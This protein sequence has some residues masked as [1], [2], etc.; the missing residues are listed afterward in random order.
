MSVYG[1]VQLRS[2]KSLNK[3]HKASR[4][5]GTGGSSSVTRCQRC[6]GVVKG[7]LP[8]KLPRTLPA[9]A[10]PATAAQRAHAVTVLATLV[11]PHHGT[12]ICRDTYCMRIN[13]SPKPSF[14][15]A[16]SLASVPIAW[17][18]FTPALKYLQVEDAGMATVP[19]AA[20]LNI[21]VH[22]V[23]AMALFALFKYQRRTE[24][25]NGGQLQYQRR[26]TTPRLAAFQLS[27]S[28]QSLR[29]MRSL[30]AA[31]ELGALI[32]LGREYFDTQ[33]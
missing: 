31:T 12:S 15:H 5:V 27:P 3:V 18:T 16:A 7:R 8:D 22:G 17:G 14:A 2:C 28:R 24:V 6:A 20:L 4:W 19:P 32:F 10:A 1:H 30:M 13:T 23:G 9:G 11:R 29:D 26:T 21:G 33:T 25:S